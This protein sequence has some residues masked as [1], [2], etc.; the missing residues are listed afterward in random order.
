MALAA[1]ERAHAL[2]SAGT[3]SA[4]SPMPSWADPARDEVRELLRRLRLVAAEAALATGEPR[5]AAGYAAA[6]MT[7]D[8]LDEAAHR[9]YMSATAAAGEQAQGAGRLR[10]A[11]PAAQR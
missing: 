6:A 7:A 10:R 4:T 11:P 1:A 8:P 3:A 2:L 5:L 9:W